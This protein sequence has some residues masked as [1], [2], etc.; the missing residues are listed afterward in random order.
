MIHKHIL[1]SGWIRD[2][3]TFREC[4]ECRQVF[5]CAGKNMTRAEKSDFTYYRNMAIYWLEKHGST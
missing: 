2:K 3:Q 4:V 1:A 5:I